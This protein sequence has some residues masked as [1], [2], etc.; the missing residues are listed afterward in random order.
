GARV[1]LVRGFGQRRHGGACGA[2]RLDG[3]D[4]AAMPRTLAL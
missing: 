3:R 1:L 4:A 2:E